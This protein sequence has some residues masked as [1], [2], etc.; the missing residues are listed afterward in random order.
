MPPPDPNGPRNKPAGDVLHPVDRATRRGLTGSPV[1]ATCGGRHGPGSARA[2][3][4]AAAATALFVGAWIVLLAVPPVVFLRWRDARLAEVSAPAAQA[5][6]D[7][8]RADMRQRSDGRGPVR[9]KVPRSP[10]PPERI[11]LRDYPL[12]V[13]AAWVIFV[14]VLGAVIGVLLRGAMGPGEA[15]SLRASTAEDQPRREGHHEKQHERD[16]Q[17]AD[18]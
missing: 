3:R 16:A 17:D 10:E 7:R 9:H 8:F 18:E 13:V 4:L 5:D 6:W 14:G 15:E 2:V 1:G 11:W 12:V